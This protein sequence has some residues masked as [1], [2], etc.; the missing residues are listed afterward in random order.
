MTVSCL[1]KVNISFTNVLQRP[2]EVVVTVADGA[3]KPKA[4]WGDVEKG[5][6][7]GDRVPTIQAGT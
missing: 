2:T 7:G 6:K 3:A 4:A 1:S 5:K